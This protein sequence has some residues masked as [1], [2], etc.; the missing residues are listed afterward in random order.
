MPVSLAIWEGE[1]RRIRRFE[2]SVGKKLM[3]PPSQPMGLV[4]CACFPSYVGSPSRRTVVQVI[5]GINAR[6]YS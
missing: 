5:L 3:R 4:T 2:D 6:L 1:S